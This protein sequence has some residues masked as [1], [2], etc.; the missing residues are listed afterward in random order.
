MMIQYDLLQQGSLLLRKIAY[1]FRVGK[2]K[3]L[4]ELDN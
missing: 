1:R 3:P 4:I 2:V